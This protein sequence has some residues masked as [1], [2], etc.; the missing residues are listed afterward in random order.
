MDSC[1]S[2]MCYP[3]SNCEVM[4]KWYADSSYH[5]LI[6]LGLYCWAVS[7]LLC[8]LGQVIWAWGASVSPDAKWRPRLLHRS[9]LALGSSLQKQL[10]SLC[11]NSPPV[12]LQNVI[13]QIVSK[14]IVMKN[15]AHFFDL[16]VSL[17]SGR[18]PIVSVKC[19]VW[20]VRCCWN[21]VC[22][23]TFCTAMS[24]NS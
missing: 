9:D 2:V 11:W 22:C 14:K 13:P 1:C 20:Y 10:E 18:I 8:H 7:G 5:Y 24:I 21:H 15:Q 3:S 4:R 23:H 12:R 16:A 17:R 19:T 6:T